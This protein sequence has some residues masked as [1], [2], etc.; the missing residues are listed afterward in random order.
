MLQSVP[1][2]KLRNCYT[3][4]YT[5][6]DTLHVL[7]RHGNALAF[8]PLDRENLLVKALHTSHTTNKQH[9]NWH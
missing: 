1:K 6:S 3:E 8:L 7:S 4:T 2:V 5:Q 9:L